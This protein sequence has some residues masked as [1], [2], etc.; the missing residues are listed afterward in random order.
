MTWYGKD[1]A[2]TTDSNTTMNW[3]RGHPIPADTFTED[4]PTLNKIAFY[5][6]TSA[7]GDARVAVYQGG[8][9]TDPSGATL[10]AEGL[11]TSPTTTAWNE[12]TASLE[13]LDSTKITW[14]FVKG[15]TANGA[16]VRYSS[17]SAEAEDWYSTQG[18]YVS[19]VV[20]SDPTVAYAATWPTDGGSQSA[21][22]YNFRIEV[23]VGEGVFSVTPSEFDMDTADVDIVGAGFEASQGTGSVYLSDATTLAG[24]TLEVDLDSVIGTWSDTAV[25]NINLSNLSASLLTDLH[26]LGPGARYVIVVNDS[27]DEFSYPVTLHR[28][29]GFEMV[30]SSD[31]ADVGEATTAKLTAPATKTTA[32][33][34]G[35]RAVDIENP[36]DTT[37]DLGTDEYREDVWNIEAK[38]LSREIQYQFRVVTD[39]VV[40]G[41]YSVD[42]RVTI[43]SVTGTDYE[44]SETEAVGVTDNASTVHD[45]A[46]SETET[47]GVTDSTQRVAA[48]ERAITDT[49]G[50]TDSTQHGTD[51]ARA[52]TD[53]V[54]VTDTAATASDIRT[55]FTEAVDVTDLPGRIA[56]AFREIAEAV[57]VADATSN[58]EDNRETVT[59]SVG[60]T[61]TTGR[62]IGTERTVSDGLS[63]TDSPQVATAKTHTVIDE[64][65]LS[66]STYLAIVAVRSES[67]LIGVTDSVGRVVDPA[68]PVV[69]DVGLTDTVTVAGANHETAADPVGVTDSTGRATV[70]KRT[71][72][73]AVGVTDATSIGSGTQVEVTDTV[74]VTDSTADDLVSSPWTVGYL[75]ASDWRFRDDTET[76]N[77][78]AG[79]LAAM[80]TN[81]SYT[82]DDG[83]LR[84]RWAGIDDEDEDGPNPA[85]TDWKLVYRI[86][87]G[88]W[89][90]IG[91]AVAVNYA[92]STQYDDQDTTKLWSIYDGVASETL[93]CE[94]IGMRE[95]EWCFEIDSNEVSDTD[96]IDFWLYYR[97]GQAGTWYGVDDGDSLPR[98]TVSLLPIGEEAT[99]QVGV[100]DSTSTSL[101]VPQVEISDT[102]GVSDQAVDDT[103][104]TVSTES[105]GM[106]PI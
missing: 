78:D 29:H 90:D 91:T 4:S 42:P 30:A 37:V 3:V 77:T 80:Q 95:L 99:E 68:R 48:T 22:W 20:S 72:T 18:R 74:G 73:E 21:Y 38:P 11:I 47:V 26:T 94:N 46:R 98:L 33:F 17:A 104:E 2:P 45:A 44:E 88:A 60:V 6:G 56:A 25:S 15:T 5:T 105:W 82:P 66:D 13:T 106:I 50:V 12:F 81:I 92:E 100:T 96:E 71:V 61:D 10:V 41:T 23:L 19:S 53:T 9:L 31:I 24:S 65:G 7:P 85:I 52:I 93:T 43:T 16:D 32:D 84:L 64:L 36:D 86:N 51:A 27:A 69:D 59:D 79:W 34:G 87:A 40:L 54:D 76:P 102:V 39:G 103:V 67:D 58:N 62:V 8:S 83:P 63:L 55:V 35:G 70:T 89:T 97:Q 14:V 1:N 49:V 28:P 101:R 57:A 75:Y